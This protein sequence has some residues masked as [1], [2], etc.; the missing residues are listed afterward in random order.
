MAVVWFPEEEPKSGVNY[1]LSGDELLDLVRKAVKDNAW[2]FEM[3][4]RGAI[5]MRRDPRDI[6]REDGRDVGALA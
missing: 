6:R 2:H 1:K 4:G 5:V 3:L